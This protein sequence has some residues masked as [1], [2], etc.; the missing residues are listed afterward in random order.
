MDKLLDVGGNILS[1]RWVKQTFFYPRY[2]F[3][4]WT[5]YR[6]GL[7]LVKVN[8]CEQKINQSCKLSATLNLKKHENATE[9]QSFLEPKH[10]KSRGKLL[11]CLHN[12]L[13]CLLV[14]C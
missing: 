5:M 8:N 14:I 10:G 4:G 2:S 13:N 12:R 6:L 11:K 7:D 1:S 3:L 9:D